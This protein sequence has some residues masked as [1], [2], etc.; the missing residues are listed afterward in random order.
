MNGS[1]LIA[2]AFSS[3]AVPTHLHYEVHVDGKAVD[4]LFYIL[5]AY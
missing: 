1:V 3:G 4:P 2:D 5:D